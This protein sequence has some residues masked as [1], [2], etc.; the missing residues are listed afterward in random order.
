MK[1][2]I[3]VG[4]I[5]YEPSTVLGAFSSPEKAEAAKAEKWARGFD[6]YEIIEAPIDSLISRP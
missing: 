6:D 3:L 2:Y 1:V 5:S 4:L